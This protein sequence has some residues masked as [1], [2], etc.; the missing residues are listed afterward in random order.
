M[1]IW[2]VSW[3]ARALWYYGILRPYFQ[4]VQVNPAG[5]GSRSVEG[6]FAWMLAILVTTMG[7]LVVW[8]VALIATVPRMNRSVARRQRAM[9]LGMQR[10]PGCL[11]EIAGVPADAATGLTRCPECAAQWRADQNVLR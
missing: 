6:A 3:A 8:L 10:C 2:L 5:T 11:Y 7:L 4:A 9:L 1:V